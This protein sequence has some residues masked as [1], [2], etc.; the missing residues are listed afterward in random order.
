MDKIVNKQKYLLLSKRQLD[1]DQIFNE[2]KDFELKIDPK[3]LG[4]NYLNEL[5]QIPKAPRS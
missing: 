1:D 4:K 3:E 5:K 2:F